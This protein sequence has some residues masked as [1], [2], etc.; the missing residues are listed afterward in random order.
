MNYKNVFTSEQ[1]ISNL[2]KAAEIS[3][4]I[5]RMLREEV[6]E[7]VTAG[8]IDELAAELCKKNGVKASFKGVPG[9]K[10]SYPASICISV[11]DEVLHAIPYKNKIFKKGDI[12][13]LDF[14]VI[15]NGFYTDHC[16]TV[17]LEPLNTEE[18][19]LIATAKLCIDTAVK[20]AIVDKRIGDISYA[21][22]TVAQ[23]AGFNFITTYCGHGIGK[24]LHEAPEVPSWGYRNSGD[25]LIEGMVLCVEN[26][27][28]LGSSDLEMDNDGWTLR[29]VD[30]SK[31]AMFEH[32]V[33]VR[34]KYPEIL[35]LLD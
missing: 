20:H 9:V 2:R 14:G 3:S 6:K 21:M 10:S 22:Q 32:M 23:M 4:S 29:T 19:K 34:K 12:V 7:G 5:L 25:R 31:T 33:I 11:N 35:T 27:L 8:E 30:G 24:S 13:K 16:I 18:K 28:S 26:Q 1:D 17:G 15:Y